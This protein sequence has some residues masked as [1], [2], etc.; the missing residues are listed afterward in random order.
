MTHVE[1]RHM[2]GLREGSGDLGAVAIVIIEGNIAGHVVI[3]L[4]RAGLCRIRRPGDGGQG[5]DVAP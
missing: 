2:R 1:T 3:K 4:R 5:I